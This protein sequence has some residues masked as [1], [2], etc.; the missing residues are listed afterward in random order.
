MA[1]SLPCFKNLR[2]ISCVMGICWRTSGS[3]SQ[4]GSPFAFSPSPRPRVG[5]GVWWIALA[6][7]PCSCL[8]PRAEKTATA[9]ALWNIKSAISLKLKKSKN[10]R[11]DGLRRAS[12][13]RFHRGASHSVNQWSNK[14]R[15]T[16]RPPSLYVI[17]SHIGNSFEGHDCALASLRESN[18]RQRYGRPSGTTCCP[19]WEANGVCSAQRTNL[20][21]LS[22][23]RLVNA[24]SFVTVRAFSSHALA[25]LPAARAARFQIGARPSE[26][27]APTFAISNTAGEPELPV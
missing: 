8:R 23:A 20:A 4:S 16:T 14:T 10:Y 2:Q 27:R 13:R 21:G 7:S 24:C 19:K 12:R 3:T 5:P 9:A 18:P 1:T 25:R 22:P 17:K 6:L 15:I 11:T 26:N